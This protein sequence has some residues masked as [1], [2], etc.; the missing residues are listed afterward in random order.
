M[1][2]RPPRST[3]AKTLFPYT[4]LFRSGG[5]AGWGGGGAVWGGGGWGGGGAGREQRGVVPSFHSLVAGLMMPNSSSQVT[6]LGSRST[7]TIFF[8]MFVYVLLRDRITWTQ[9]TPGYTAH[10]TRH[11]THQGAGSSQ[12]LIARELGAGKVHLVQT[13]HGDDWRGQTGF[14]I[15]SGLHSTRQIGRAHV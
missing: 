4:T 10:A 14:V 13:V 9:P 15:S 8:F 6:A 3:Q 2:R 1:I 12:G 5:G 7:T 11:S